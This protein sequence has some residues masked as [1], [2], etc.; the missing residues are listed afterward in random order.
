MSENLYKQGDS[1]TLEDTLGSSP[2]PSSR[3]VAL[4]LPTWVLLASPPESLEPFLSDTGTPGQ[5]G[6]SNPHG[7]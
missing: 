7:R 1:W 4:S 2:G 3:R 5:A 6:D